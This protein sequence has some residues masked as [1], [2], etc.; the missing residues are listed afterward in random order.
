MT[1]EQIR[2]NAAN[3]VYNFQPTGVITEDRLKCHIAGAHSR[4]EEVEQ[5]KESKRKLRLRL[6]QKIY[7]LRNPWISVADRLPEKINKFFSDF[8]LVMYTRGG[9]PYPFIT[10]YDYECGMWEIE[11][12]THWMPIP[13]LSPDEQ[14][15]RGLKQMQQ[16]LEKGG[17]E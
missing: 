13:P 2:Q 14:L 1:R 11:N 15:I 6:M 3:Y 4:D 5:W 12:V 9:K 17:S 10:R 7:E 16:E 8:V